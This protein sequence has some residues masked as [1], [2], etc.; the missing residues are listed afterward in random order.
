MDGG[1]ARTAEPFDLE[2]GSDAESPSASGAR[3]TSLGQ[4]RHLAHDGTSRRQLVRESTITQFVD[5]G[6]LDQARAELDGIDEAA[7]V[8]P[9]VKDGRTKH[10][11]SWA[12]GSSER[13]L[14]VLEFYE[15]VD[16][17]LKIA[18]TELAQVE[19]KVTEMEG[20][21]HA[22]QQRAER[23]AALARSSKPLNRRGGVIDHGGATTKLA[24]GGVV[25]MDMRKAAVITSNPLSTS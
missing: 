4:R 2:S 10:V 1:V 22:Q 16:S 13:L 21:E 14:R 5:P 3:P 18:E 11:S 12:G 7:M 9:I 24:A 25:L 23:E 6:K 8:L 19:G 20:A 15:G 17:K